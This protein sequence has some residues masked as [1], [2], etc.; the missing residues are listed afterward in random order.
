[1]APN[2]IMFSIFLASY[3][4]SLYNCTDWGQS[5]W[6]SM[7]CFSRINVNHKGKINGSIINL[8]GVTPPCNCYLST[9]IITINEN[10]NNNNYNKK[11]IYKGISMRQTDKLHDWLN[12]EKL[13]LRITLYVSIHKAYKC[14]PDKI[15]AMWSTVDPKI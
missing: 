5:E 3:S 13:K 12:E 4:I 1:M 6:L 10:N 2:T 14:I 15:F 8:N 11:H 7:I 9:V